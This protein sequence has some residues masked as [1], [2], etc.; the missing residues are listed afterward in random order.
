MGFT[1]VEVGIS[2]PADRE[3]EERIEVLV[4]TGAT[5]S[6]IPR[7]LLERLGV[8]SIDSREFRGFGGVVTRDTGG[9]V[10]SYDGVPALVAVVF[11]EEDDP[12]I[13][14]VTA[15]ESLGYQVDPVTNELKPTEMLLL[16]LW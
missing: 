10:M 12:A 16:G 2:N 8:A 7:S 11:G 13:M 3:R 14:G 5:L 6:V 1:R 15:L 4:D 9:V